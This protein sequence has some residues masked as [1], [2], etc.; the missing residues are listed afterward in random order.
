MTVK[1]M[2]RLTSNMK[3]N[4]NISDREVQMVFLGDI[5][6]FDKRKTIKFSKIWIL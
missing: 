5:Q 3:L 4:V 1:N 6:A 2:Q